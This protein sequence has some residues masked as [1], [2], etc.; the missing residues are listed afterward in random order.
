ME[1][2]GSS[3]QTLVQVSL[4]VGEPLEE[5]SHRSKLAVLPAKKVPSV[6]VSFLVGAPDQLLHQ[7]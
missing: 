6:R 7:A 5:V 4:T 3:S 1:G 2:S